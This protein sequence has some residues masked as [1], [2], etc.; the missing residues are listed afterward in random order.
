MDTTRWCYVPS[1]ARPT[2]VHQSRPVA[3]GALESGDQAVGTRSLASPKQDGDVALTGST[4]IR[5]ANSFVELKCLRASRDSCHSRRPS[6]VAEPARST[7]LR[8]VLLASVIFDG[9]CVIPARTRSEPKMAK[10]PIFAV[11]RLHEVYRLTGRSCR[12]NYRIPPCRP[13]RSIPGVLKR[14]LPFF[15]EVLLTPAAACTAGQRL[16]RLIAGGGPDRWRRSGGAVPMTMLKSSLCLL[17]TRHG[18]QRR[19]Y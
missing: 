13:G 8:A 17:A 6:C 9:S 12:R 18:G 2:R 4:S 14:V 10:S 5:I 7:F 16:Y 11:P 1:L 19:G 3:M 15:R